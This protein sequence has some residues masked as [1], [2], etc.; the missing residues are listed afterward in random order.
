MLSF[1]FQ[2]PTRIYFGPGKI[3]YI[4][5]YL[6]PVGKKPLI[7]TGKSSMRETGTL[8][9]IIDLLKKGNIDPVVFEGIEPNPRHTTCDRAAAL[10]RKERCDFVVGLGGG[11]V[12]D[13]A[14]AVAVTARTGVSIWEYVYSGPDKPQRIIKEALPIV[15]IPTIAATGSEADSGGIISNWETHEKTGIWGQALFP[16]VSIVD[17]ELTFTCPPHYTADGGVDIISHVIEGYFTASTEAYV[18]D[19]IAEGIIKTVMKYL[20][21]AIKNGKDL[22]A[23]THLSWSSTL[24]LSGF[25]NSGRGGGFPLHSL[26]HV[27]S[28]HYD[29]SHGRGLALLLPGLMDYTV[30]ARPEKYIEMGVNI[31]GIGFDDEDP[32]Q[33]ARISI[34][35]MKGWLASIGRLLTFSEL[36]IDDSKF[37]IMA[38]DAVRLYMRDKGYLE[39]PRPIDRAGVIE[40]LEMTR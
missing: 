16:T 10:A 40:I 38:D 25:V 19:R 26:E 5:K 21:R 1:D 28:A 29:I 11:S 30:E 23:R 6:K 33:A 4:G 24:A 2:L 32:L 12:M 15:C 14:K 7:V 36:G 17:P 39:N 35:S 8:D 31:F 9:R 18:Q 13:G 3:D 27:V 20:P 37:E 22:E 34:D